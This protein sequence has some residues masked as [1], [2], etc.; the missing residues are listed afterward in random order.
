MT[1]VLIRCDASLTIGS[2]HVMRCSTLAR[3]LQAR[4]AEVVFACRR[5]LGDRIAQLAEEFRVL[6]LPV[7]PQPEEGAAEGP[8][9]SGRDLYAAWVGCSEEQDASDCLAALAAASL[10]PPNWLV[11]DHYGLS[12][13]WQRLM[14][15]GL[16]NPAILVID[17]LADRRHQPTVLMDANRL[18]PT[19]A[20]PHR[21]LVPE[22]CTTLL[23]PPYALLDPIYPQLQPLLPVRKQLSRLLVLEG[24]SFQSHDGGSGGPQPSTSSPS[25][26]RCS[27]RP[28]RA[29]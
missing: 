14:Q 16:D 26:G 10:D 5:Q 29:T 23:G 6:T 27:A 13:A 15:D 4:G 3:A 28:G 2:G 20:D 1:S 21:D 9:L 17:D 7:C 24:G 22:A 11:V 25:V 12:V 8:S 18:D 19:A